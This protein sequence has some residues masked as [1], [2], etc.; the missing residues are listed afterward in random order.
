MFSF[1]GIIRKFLAAAL[2]GA[3]VMAAIGLTAARTLPRA[4]NTAMDA[5]AIKTASAMV[6][7]VR[8]DAFPLLIKDIEAAAQLRDIT[9]DMGGAPVADKAVVAQLQ[10]MGLG[11]EKG[12]MGLLDRAR[13]LLGKAQTLLGLAETF[14][15]ESEAASE[16]ASLKNS[17]ARID[18]LIADDARH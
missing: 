9:S 11:E 3:L 7:V 10:D 16:T 17:L 5:A 2:I 12:K 13:L 18:A 14:E 8:G 6:G 1:V 4:D 15:P